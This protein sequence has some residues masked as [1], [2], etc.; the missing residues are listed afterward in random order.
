MNANLLASWFLG[1]LGDSKTAKLKCGATWRASPIGNKGVDYSMLGLSL[2]VEFYPGGEKY[3]LE[4]SRRGNDGIIREFDVPYV[5]KNKNKPNWKKVF[6]I[7]RGVA[8]ELVDLE[9]LAN[10]K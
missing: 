1:F 4:V 8:K 3:S 10:S 7:N 6:D 5:E 9:P 2:S